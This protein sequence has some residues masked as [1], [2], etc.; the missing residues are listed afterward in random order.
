MNEMY[1]ID[2][3]NGRVFKITDKLLL[4]TREW[5][6]RLLQGGDARIILDAVH[7]SGL[8]NGFVVK[9]WTIPV[10]NRVSILETESN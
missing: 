5:Q 6:Q 7:Y 8:D 4:V 3:A 2:V 10:Q 1:G 9:K